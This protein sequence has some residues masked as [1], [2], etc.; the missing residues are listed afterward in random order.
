MII[1]LLTDFGESEYVGMMK[2]V[3]ARLCPNAKIIDLT[4]SIRK[5]DIRHGCFV[6]WQSYRFFPKST[7]FVVVVDPGV[8]TE[9]RGII[10]K[11]KDYIFI[12]PDNGVFTLINDVD[13]IIEIPQPEEASLTFHGR[14]V[15]API[16][17]K[18]ACGAK[19]EELGS[20]IKSFKKLK[21]RKPERKGDK[22]FGEVLCI[23][24]FGNIITNIPKEILNLEYNQ[25]ITIK[26][27][28]KFKV[29]FL[30]SYGYAEKNELLA[31]I[32]SANTLEIAVN[33]GN[34]A[35]KLGVKGG[36]EVVINL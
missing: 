12:G 19:I 26:I 36:E 32:G 16:A 11:T 29:R 4:H 10:L 33:Q 3:I 18:I 27:K 1:A 35:E 9:R 20:E 25:S 22:I 6:L 17:A 15:F 28:E 2:G 5:F 7:V 13:K 30:K 14:D 34:A 31:L 23:D 21:I 24:A 8:G